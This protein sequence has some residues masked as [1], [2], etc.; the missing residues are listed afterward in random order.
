MSEQ[1]E[2]VSVT[3]R[4]DAIEERHHGGLAGYRRSVPEAHAAACRSDGVV[5]RVV[6]A[7]REAARWWVRVLRM[8]G[9]REDDIRVQ[10]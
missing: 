3:V 4:V 7:D 8:K 6:F 10:P 5:T 9:L 1:D 2:Q